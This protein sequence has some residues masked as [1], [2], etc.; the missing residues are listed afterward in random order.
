MALGGG[1]S[2]GV[3]AAWKVAQGTVHL[4][5]R[6]TLSSRQ[7]A[8]WPGAL[9]SSALVLGAGGVALRG[10]LRSAT[11]FSSVGLPPPSPFFSSRPLTRTLPR[12]LPLPCTV[13]S[14]QECIA[15]LVGDLDA[16]DTLAAACKA[17]SPNLN[18]FSSPGKIMPSGRRVLP[19]PARPP[20]RSQPKPLARLA[21]E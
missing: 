1:A 2:S 21:S 9:G 4:C 7:C 13:L 18:Q 3:H 20:G 16:V 12:P 5:C 14:A 19:S 8:R 15:L 10:V 6:S 11:I 17:Q